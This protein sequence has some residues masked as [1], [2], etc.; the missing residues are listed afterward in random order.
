MSTSLMTIGHAYYIAIVTNNTSK[1]PSVGFDQRQDMHSIVGLSNAVATKFPL[2]FNG[3]C[4]FVVFP[5]GSKLAWDKE[6]GFAHPG[7]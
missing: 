6:R 7:N 3:V 2:E 5:D 4:T 1:D